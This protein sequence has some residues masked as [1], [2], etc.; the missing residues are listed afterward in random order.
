MCISFINL[1]SKTTFTSYMLYLFYLARPVSPVTCFFL[2]RVLRTV[3]CSVISFISVHIQTV[4]CPLFHS[5]DHTAADDPDEHGWAQNV[6]IRW[7]FCATFGD[8]KLTVFLKK[9]SFVSE[10]PAYV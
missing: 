9:R 2:P 5:N 1:F 10:R 3:V 6:D 7:G 8:L 4:L